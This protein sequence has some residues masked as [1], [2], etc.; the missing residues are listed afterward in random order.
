M[1]ETH[2][3]SL[4]FAMF[5]L[6]TVRAGTL[7]LESAR[8][9]NTKTAVLTVIAVSRRDRTMRQTVFALFAREAAITITEVFR[10][11]QSSQLACS[12]VGALVLAGL[13]GKKKC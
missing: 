10:I 1:K 3:F 11:V 7:I 6:P 9:V 2:I 8:F 12:M 13:V 5:S 4:H